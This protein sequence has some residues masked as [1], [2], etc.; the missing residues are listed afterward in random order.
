MRIASVSRTGGIIVLA[1]LGT[2]ASGPD[3]RLVSA[4][5]TA[6]ITELRLLLKQGV[7][8]KARTKDGSTALHWAAYQDN[9]ESVELLIRAGADVNAAND[10]GATALWAAAL[11]GSAPIVQKLLNAGANPNAAL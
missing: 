5:K 1:V 8:P 9:L 11:N 7:D 3:A 10:L 6:N 4:V 2:A